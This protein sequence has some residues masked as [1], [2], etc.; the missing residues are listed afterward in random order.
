MIKAKQFIKK[1][2]KI[3]MHI[4]RLKFANG[5][6]IVSHKKL[7]FHIQ[8]NSALFGILDIPNHTIYLFR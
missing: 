5:N 4:I 6:I 7:Y 3:Y 2:G 8:L 1:E